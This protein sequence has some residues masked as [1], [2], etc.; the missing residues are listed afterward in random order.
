MFDDLHLQAMELQTL[1]YLESHNVRT[2]IWWSFFV[3]DD[4]LHVDFVNFQMLHYI[5]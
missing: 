4:N 1:L 3:I 2:S 5:M